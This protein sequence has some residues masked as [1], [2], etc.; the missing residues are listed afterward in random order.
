MRAITG[1]NNQN[2]KL[3]AT[4]AGLQSPMIIICGFIN[5]SDPIHIQVGY[6]L[7]H[8]YTVYVFII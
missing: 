1:P 5:T 6:S 8:L 4:I 7:I 2:K 3:K